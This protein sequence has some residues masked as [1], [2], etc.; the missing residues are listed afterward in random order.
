MSQDV[1]V[2]LRADDDREALV[3][4]VDCYH[5]LSLCCVRGWLL[6]MLRTA[7]LLKVL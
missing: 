1:D 3:I 7:L 5:F 6:L 4:C 2:A